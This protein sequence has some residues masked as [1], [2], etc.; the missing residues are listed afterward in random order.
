[1]A[2]RNGKIG[3]APVLVRVVKFPIHPTE[4]QMLTLHLVSENLRLIW[5]E[6]LE[7]RQRYFNEHLK[8]LYEVLKNSS[9]D[10]FKVAQLKAAIKTMYEGAPVYHDKEDHERS[11]AS[12]LTQMR[13]A[14]TDFAAVPSG[15]QQEGLKTLEGAYASFAQLRARGDKTAR[16]PRIKDPNGFCEVQGCVSWQLATDTLAIIPQKPLG[17]AYQHA[18]RNTHS[19]EI[20]LSPGKALPGGATLRFAIPEYQR[21]VLSWAVKLNKFTL[22]RDRKGRHWISIAYAKPIPDGVEL[23]PEEVVFVTLG[24]SYVGVVSQTA[25]ETIDLWRPDK[26]W[27]SLIRNARNRGLLPQLQSE[28]ALK[29]SIEGGYVTAETVARARQTAENGTLYGDIPEDE[30]KLFLAPK[31][32]GSRGYDGLIAAVNRMYEI[33]RC[34]Q[35]QNQREVI[36]HRL[37]R[38]GVHFVVVAHSP[39][40]AKEDKLADKTKVERRG[41][42]GLNWSVQ[43]TGSLA[44]LTQLLKQ[45]AAEWG[46]SVSTIYLE[47]Y[48]AGD[49]R[50]RKVPAAEAARAQYLSTA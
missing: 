42:L 31:Q 26:K 14:H 40:R 4:E 1:M 48:P 49:A 41:D 2:V 20:V 22:Y 47:G 30:R 36:V 34:Q 23:V 3:K 6:C 8:P 9:G 33:M 38:Y 21:L 32:K 39:I 16:P 10:P 43:N 45:K 13:H 17:E 44:R 18:I 35:L 37:A 27:I 5:N 50:A 15:W 29:R 28:E 12:W 46:G 11:Q 7:W 24:A 25:K 19:M